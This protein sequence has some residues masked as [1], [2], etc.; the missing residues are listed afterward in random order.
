MFL[1]CR[2]RSLSVT[3]PLSSSPSPL[4]SFGDPH[5]VE[6]VGRV[7]RVGSRKRQ[8]GFGFLTIFLLE[9]TYPDIKHS[10]SIALSKWEYV[11]RGEVG[12]NLVNNIT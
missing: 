5:P 12:V 3:G 11:G 2:F 4:L 8:G 9:I 7:R 6:E 10:L 1:F